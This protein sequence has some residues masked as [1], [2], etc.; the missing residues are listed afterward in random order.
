MNENCRCPRI[1]CKRHGD[2]AACGEFHSDA[3]KVLSF[4]KWS[5]ITG[6]DEPDSKV[7]A[8]AWLSNDR[9]QWRSM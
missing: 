2:C 9:N 8:R 4:C 6:F 1:K 5:G 7:A 3:E